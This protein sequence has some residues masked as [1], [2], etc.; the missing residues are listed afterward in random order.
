MRAGSFE[1]PLHYRNP[2]EQGGQYAREDEPIVGGHIHI[3]PYKKNAAAGT[4]GSDKRKLV[5][6]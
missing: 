3:F 5:V 4:C 6:V 2:G 1:D